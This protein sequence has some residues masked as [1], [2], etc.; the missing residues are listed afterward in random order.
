MN[1][2]TKFLVMENKQKQIAENLAYTPT[3]E[4]AEFE[5]CSSINDQWNSEIAKMRDARLASENEN[6]RN[7]IL[8]LLD[9][10]EERK[11]RLVERLDRRVLKEEENSKSFITEDN[12][13]QAIEQALANP[14]SF[15][16]AISPEGLK[17][18]EKQTEEIEIKN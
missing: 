5:R 18:G 15:M 3:D 12:L 13:Q 14:T 1:S 2:L 17:V 7:Q 10:Q 6:R 11:K 9:R 16:Y 4:Q 8:E